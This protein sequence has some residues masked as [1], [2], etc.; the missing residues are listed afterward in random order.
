MHLNRFDSIE[1]FEEQKFK[2]DSNFETL[3]FFDRKVHSRFT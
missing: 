1:I 3:M 2:F